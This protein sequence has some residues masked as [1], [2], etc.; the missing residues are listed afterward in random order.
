M[1]VKKIKIKIIIA[2]IKKILI[3]RIDFSFFRKKKKHQKNIFQV[4]SVKK[5]KN[6]T[7]FF[8]Q[9]ELKSRKSLGR[10]YYY[11]AIWIKLFN[12]INKPIRKCNWRKIM[13]FIAKF[14]YRS[15]IIS[16]LLILVYSLGPR[17]SSAPQLVTIT[18]RSEWED[19]NLE[20]ISATSATDAIELKSDGAWTARI[21]SPTP[22]NISFGSTSVLVGNYLYVTRGY[23]DKAFYRYNIENNEWDII[24]DLPQPAHYGCDA[25]YDGSG[26]L[27][28]IF[29]G[30]SKDFYKYNIENE[31]WT[32]LPDLL[33]TIYAGAGIEFD[34]T[35]L[36]ITRGQASTDFWKFDISE[37]SWYNLA[38]VSATLYTGSNLVYGQNG[39]MYVTR[40]YNSNTFY[41]YSI[42]ANSWSTL[43]IAPS[44]FYGE[45]KGTYY[46]GYI[47]FLRSNNTNSFYR[48]SIS[49]NSW[50]TLE[51]APDTTNY[52]SLTYNN[53]D[54]YIYAL[55]GNGQYH[56]WKFDP[57]AGTTGEWIGPKNLPATVGTGG[58]LIWNETEGAGAYLYAVRGGSNNFYRY[59]INT[60][61][62]ANMANSPAALSY[63]TK[64]TYHNG[65]IYIPRGSNN[66]TFYR[67]DIAGNSWSSMTDAPAS[68]GYGSV[69]AY[70]NSDGYI[71]VTRGNGT[72]NFYR[73]DI[74]GNSWTTLS[75]ITTTDGTNYYSYTGARLESD[76]TNLYLMPGDG[77]TA[78][79]KYDTSNGIWEELK[80]CPFI[81]SYGTDM[82]YYNGKIYALAGY[83][84]D[85][86][87]EYDISAD[88]W[89][90]LPTNQKY[91]YGRGPYNGASLEYAGNDSFYSTPGFGLSDMWSYSLGAGNYL[92]SGTYISDT[93]DLSYVSSWISLTV[94]DN[95]PANTAIAIETRTSDDG[96]NWS[97]WEALSGTNI[98]SP[99]NRYIQVK[100][101][102]STSDGVS[103]PTVYDFTVAYNS[104][105]NDPSNPTGVNAYSQ[106]IGGDLLISG[107]AYKHAHPYFSWT[108]ASD[109]ESG[110]AGYYVYFGTSDTADPETA[111][112]YQEASD[113]TVNL[114]MET[115]NYYL[116]IKT[117]DNDGNVSDSTYSAFTYN[118]SGVSP[119][120]SETKTN[121]SDFNS[122]TL[123]NVVS[124][125][126]G[127]MR[128]KSVDGFW[129]ENRL[130]YAPGG[131]Y[132]GGELAYAETEGKLYTFRGANTT[133][134]YSYDIETDTWSTLANAPATVYYGGSLVEG[135]DGY[136]YGARG[137]NTSEFWRYNITNNTWEVMANA[138]KNFYYGSSL[139]YDNNRYIYV[140][141]GNDD[142]FYRYDTQNNIWTTLNNVEFGNPNEYDGQ[143]VYVG[144]DSVYDG[145]NNIYVM[146][147]NYYPYFA[148]YS[149]A[150]NQ[151]R[152]EKG[153]TWTPLT[154]APIG[155]YAGGSLAY[156]SAKDMIYMLSG[157]YR[158]NFFKYDVAADTWSQLPEIPFYVEY[159]GSL[160]VV[161]DYIYAT[162]GAN[163]TGFYRFN[164]NENSWESPQRGFFGPSTNSGSSYFGFYYGTNIAEDNNGNIYI[165]RGN[166]DNTFG[167]YNIQTGVFTELA[168]LPVGAY[169]GA[170]LIYN[171]DE[172]AIYMTSGDLRTRRSGNINN[173]FM[174]YD[175][176]ANSWEIITTDRVP[177]QTTY[178]SS[179]TY[180]GSRYIYLTRGG[181]SNTWWRYDTQ[182]SEG[183]RWSSNLP[184]ISGWNQGYGG[185]IIYKD[186]YIY[187]ICG[188]NT[189]TFWRYDVTGGSWTQ[190]NNIPGNVYIG[191]SLVDGND[192]Y[193]YVTRGYNTNDFYRYNISGGTWETI[194]D[195][196]GQIYQGGASV[197]S[198]NRIWTTAGTGTNSYNDGLYNY[199]I[200][201]ETNGTGFEK[202]GIYTSESI[203]LLSVYRWANLT[204][205]YTKPNNTS[206]AIYT[207]TSEDE[208]NWSAWDQVSNEKELGSNQYRY[209]IVS[210]VNEYIQIKIEYTSGDQIFSPTVEDYT[211]NYYQDIQAPTNPTTLNAYSASDKTTVITANTWYNY[212]TPYFEW[213]AA[214]A[215]G[216]ASDGVGGSGVAGYWVY[217]G[218]N[219]SADPFVDGVYQTATTYSTSGLTSGQDYYLKIVAQDDAGM[220]PS[221]SFQAFTY[222]FDA[223]A[224]SNPSDIS[225]TPAGYT[226]SDNY[227]F[228]WENDAVDANSG[229][230]KF[231]Y[232]TDG[233]DEGVWYDINNPEEITITIPNAEH[234]EGAYQSGKNWFYLRAVDNAGNV[235]SPISQEYYFSADAPS[236]PQNLTVTPAYS[237]GNS[238]TFEWDQPASFI[239]DVA[240]LKYYY[241]V[242]ALPNAY[243]TVETTVKAAG[244][245][246][247]AT[248]KGPNRFYVVAMDEAGNIDYD[249]YSY[250][251]FT[252][253]T[254]APGAPVNPQIFDTSDRENQEYSIA[255]KWSLPVSMDEDNFAGYVVY[256]SLEENGTY[257]EVA[258]TSGTAYVDT[259]LES[260]RYYYY[261]KS[262]DNTSNLSIASS[263]VTIIPTG[264]YTKAPDLTQEPKV[265]VK[266]FAA[267]FQWGTNREASS[268]VE[269][270]K[271]ISLGETNGQ[272]D[273]VTDHLVELTGLSAK[274]KY[275]YRVKYIDPD[276]NIGTSEIGTF[277]TLDPPTVSEFSV[278]D[279]KLDSA[280]ISWKTNTGATCALK[281]GAGS[282]TNTIEETSNASNHIQKIEGL[283]AETNYQTQ[284]ECLDEDGNEF[285]SDQYNF[286]TPVRPVVSG[287]K[288]ENKENVDLP[289]VLVEYTTN[290]P[291]TTTIYFKCD[292]N[293][294]STYFTNDKVME[295]VAEL[296]DLDPA[297]EYTLTIGGTDENG[298]EMETVEQKIT[299]R[300]DSRPPEILT[301]RA[302]GK[303]IGRGNNAQANLYVK[304]ETNEPT[305]VKINYAKGVTVS[306]FEQ[307][308]GED[309]FNT[310]H[311]ISIPAE[312]N[313]VYSYQAQVFDEANNLSETKAV[314]V[315]V[316]K[317]K[318]SATEIIVKTIS[319]RFSWISSLWK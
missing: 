115:G 113:Y 14:S 253:D 200:G 26:N 79:L 84:K 194:N 269:Y 303:V 280:Y 167:K 185:R 293:S 45:Q 249:L 237:T 258:T 271:S 33:D 188:Q 35:D 98:Q 61:N 125:S 32:K 201:S 162:R 166:Y 15:V 247:F 169:N 153:N 135:P 216:G 285:F 263:I 124:R 151:E 299:T 92:A 90:M 308:T 236:P 64:G 274:T 272:I 107:T 307:S 297:K 147:G 228:L 1:T 65:Y 163:S 52:T 305:K 290:V 6:L 149:I 192:G 22:D 191:G 31:T 99:T 54:G 34:G 251:D 156:D 101:T 139:S 230:S 76:G 266:S 8:D 91:V 114:A 260:R 318:N 11:R 129:N 10:K 63:D 30:Y 134:F 181:G 296:K 221:S 252:A 164:I 161:G 57:N 155:I 235:S 304:I 83:Y 16:L 68:L 18:T 59:D 53:S 172:D 27:Y 173:Y 120:Q 131:I 175:I 196:P 278:S 250:I 312:I 309:P 288:V 171:E 103:T 152:G 106:R 268:F 21:W 218:T 286:S 225:V 62:W 277:T 223:T 205:T 9:Y 66:G 67:Y 136:L 238:F 243:N 72:N 60:N 289:T 248:Q 43:A 41:R 5:M 245:G 207:R 159:G 276:G 123:E 259:G 116:R 78:F 69:A 317:A 51:N 184:T 58:D 4:S 197:S 319:E 88:S 214:E 313:Q 108:G 281:Y 165:V 23:G 209:D 270:G 283:T 310:Y 215:D 126:D 212:A 219:A 246:P 300:S 148:K 222:R 177:Y 264:R 39:Y 157:N 195:V 86:T 37:N 29:G 154:K 227:V 182:A 87:W 48:Y 2:E 314:T 298:I 208:V 47:Y 211:I 40:G 50:T 242:N 44:T 226:A 203:D 56:L 118:Y 244:P 176:A 198:S 104:E 28:F 142:A 145:E 179:M 96:E 141:P 93:I 204:I 105:D 256:R 267:T 301:N 306:G 311:L 241:S 85:E 36:Y 254:T 140:L 261:V 17:A 213:P 121:Q 282:Y 231:Q 202:T 284:V 199:V 42:S 133:S 292:E 275:Y 144:S 193:L 75:N 138:P 74:T 25:V 128:L 80:T 73:Y 160:K 70:N 24:D 146:Q 217:F 232:R 302:V 170:A 239:G 3:Q 210:P 143:R 102:L 38:P 240:K 273:N 119:Y 130:S 262:K 109:N 117:K 187:S 174:K 19:G 287:V 224:P 7:E 46:N 220:I 158:Q 94:T 183:S 255:I 111:G 112:I 190:L 257:T 12:F 150:D 178:G 71:Y 229:L 265:S 316:E 122:G 89:R 20:N 186:N 97:N 49:G 180:D 77:E 95:T 100:F 295:H 234:L 13:R 315:V 291:T 127:T 294:P 110:I 279:I 189:N 168:K 233:D 137:Y 55:R 132:Y 81:Q 206:L 82:T